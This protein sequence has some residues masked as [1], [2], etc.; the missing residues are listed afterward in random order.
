MPKKL[1]MRI[2]ICAC[3]IACVELRVEKIDVRNCAYGNVRLNVL[4][5]AYMYMCVLMYTLYVYAYVCMYM[6]L[7]VLMYMYKCVFMGVYICICVFF[8]LQ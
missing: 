2:C 1:Y 4:V 7:C 8:K 6:W 5:Y 3:K